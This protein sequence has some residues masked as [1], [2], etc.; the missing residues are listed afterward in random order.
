MKLNS[1]FPET[2][3]TIQSKLSTKLEAKEKENPPHWRNPFPY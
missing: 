1:L 3:K 2:R